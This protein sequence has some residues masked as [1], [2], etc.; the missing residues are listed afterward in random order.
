MTRV[1]GT[2]LPSG[3]LTIGIVGPYDLVEKIMLSGPPAGSPGPDTAW[4]LPARRLVAAA[5]RDEQESADKVARLGAS[6]DVCLFASQVPYDYAMKA[7]VLT[8]PA[9]YVPLAGSA[10][11]GAL[12]RAHLNSGHDFARASIDVLGRGAVTEAFDEIGVSAQDLHV[13]EEPAS[14]AALA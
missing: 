5:Y 14:P 13:H 2:G 8:C 10:L 12:L 3:E 7:R 4:P 11:Y 1:A 6:I 9:T